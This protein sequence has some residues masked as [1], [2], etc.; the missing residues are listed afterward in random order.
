[1]GPIIIICQFSKTISNVTN[2]ETRLSRPNYQSKNCYPVILSYVAKLSYGQLVMVQK[3]LQQRSS[4]QKY[5]L[6]EKSLIIYE[7]ASRSVSYSP[8]G[9][10]LDSLTLKFEII[11]WL[12][13][14]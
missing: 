1:M 6:L 9:P 8:L 3:C 5:W 10:P 12:H 13:E 7:D 14:N 11:W 2:W 4:G